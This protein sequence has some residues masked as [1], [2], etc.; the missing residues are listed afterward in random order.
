MFFIESAASLPASSAA[1]KQH[2]QKITLPLLVNALAR[3][4]TSIYPVDFFCAEGCIHSQ[5]Q[6][7]GWATALPSPTL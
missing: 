4:W 1:W 5:G 6:N 3:L 2:F 7:P